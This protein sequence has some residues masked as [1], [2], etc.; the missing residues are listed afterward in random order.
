MKREMSR[1]SSKLALNILELES[2]GIHGYLWAKGS[3]F[4]TSW[5]SNRIECIDSQQCI[6]ICR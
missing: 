1:N 3:N 6:Y 4:D 2:V 5:L